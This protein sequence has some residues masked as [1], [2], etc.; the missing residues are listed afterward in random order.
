MNPHTL[1]QDAFTL[2]VSSSYLHFTSPLGRILT[3][4][5]VK[6]FTWPGSIQPLSVGLLVLP[7]LC[8]A[9][10]CLSTRTERGR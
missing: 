8:L 5:S 6:A 2:Y 7:T 10:T 1:M 9:F 3:G 4:I